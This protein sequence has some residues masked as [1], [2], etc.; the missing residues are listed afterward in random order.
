MLAE[1]A[2]QPKPT[3]AEIEAQVAEDGDEWTDED[4][5]RAILVH[6]P[7]TPETIRALRTHLGLTQA[8]F[9]LRFGFA[10]DTLQQY[11]D[12]SLIPS[13]PARTLLRLIEV[14][15]DAVMRLLDP[16]HTARTEPAG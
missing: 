2:A 10:A 12:G 4:F 11:E 14:D 9:A 16:R 15:P 13:G 6:P 3:E 8:E 5:A 7:T 1:F